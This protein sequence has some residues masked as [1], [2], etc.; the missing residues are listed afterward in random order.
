[1]L[2]RMF[3]SDL[4]SDQDSNGAFLIDRSSLYFEPIINFLRCGK[5]IYEKGL[6]IE[7]IL[8]EARYFG[9]DSL[10]SLLESELSSIQI[11]P[12]DAPLTRR[13]VINAIIRTSHKE[14]LRFQGVN[15]S[16]CDL[17]KLDLRHIN[18][19]YARLSNANLSHSNLNFC[20][21]ERADLSHSNL[22]G[23]QLM[24]IKALCANFEGALLKACNFE[25]P[26]GCCRSNLEGVNFKYACLEDSNLAGVNLRVSICFLALKPI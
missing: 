14:E 12:D 2:A 24:S 25:D 6:N 8:E 23:A 7:G 16:N 11:N 26:T 5:L 3:Q 1:M 19:K 9:I 10:V 18:F 13:D 20:C 4:A 17:R 21:L 15:L 22:E